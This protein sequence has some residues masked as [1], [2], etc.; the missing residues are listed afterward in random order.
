MALDQ[1]DE[2]QQKVGQHSCVIR[3]YVNICVQKQPKDRP[4]S[5]MGSPGGSSCK[6]YPEP[7][8]FC[9]SDLQWLR[10][11][12]EF[13]ILWHLYHWHSINSVFSQEFVLE[14]FD[15]IYGTLIYPELYSHYPQEY[16]KLETLMIS[17]KGFYC[18][19]IIHLYSI[20]T[21][22]NIIIIFKDISQLFK[23]KPIFKVNKTLPW[24]QS[25]NWLLCYTGYSINPHILRPHLQVTF[26]KGEILLAE[27]SKESTLTFRTLLALTG[28]KSRENSVSFS[29]QQCTGN[30][31]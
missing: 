15:Q 26:L 20:R 24:L 21:T 10:I 11:Y 14:E 13:G 16:F 12:G 4:P 18:I 17:Q 29:I 5:A 19:S 30:P 1:V 2:I 31:S 27:V 9:S 7:Y 28:N 3:K 8:T 23:F 25:T 6:G 22:F